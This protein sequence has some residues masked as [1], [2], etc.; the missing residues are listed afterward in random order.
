MLLDQ[1]PAAFSHLQGEPRIGDEAAEAIGPLVRRAREEPRLVLPH[2]V[3][4][5]AD[6]RADDRQPRGLVHEDLQ[7][8]LPLGERRVV[9]RHHPEVE[10]QEGRGLV[11]QA[12][13]DRLRRHARQIDKLAADLDE[14]PARL[15]EHASQRLRQGGQVPQT[16]AAPDPA[17]ARRPPPGTPRLARP[18]QRT[19]RK[20]TQIDGGRKHRHVPGEARCV[21][22]EEA[23]TGDHPVAAPEHGREPPAARGGAFLRPLRPET[24]ALVG[25]D[26]E[27]GVVEIEQ[28]RRGAEQERQLPAREQLLLDQ[29]GVGAACAARQVRQIGRPASFRHEDVGV[30]AAPLQESQVLQDPQPTARMFDPAVEDT[31]NAQP[32][33]R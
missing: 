4:V 24:L 30:D 32:A 28:D 19:V 31:Q 9:E 11:L 25:A 33:S 23:V 6:R 17:D 26:R 15:R 22:G 21:F 13:R 20:E 27:H 5:R 14:D 16:R 3:A 2:Q 7:P 29:D 8:A 12:P 18:P 1:R 10:V